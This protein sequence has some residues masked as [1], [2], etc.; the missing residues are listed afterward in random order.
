MLWVPTSGVSGVLTNPEP[1]T[2][3]TRPSLMYGPYLVRDRVRVRVRARVRV[4]LRVRVRVRVR[5]RDR[6]F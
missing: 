4:R 5:V 1:R 2:V 3:T 6:G